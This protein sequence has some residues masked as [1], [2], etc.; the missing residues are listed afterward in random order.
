MAAGAGAL[1]DLRPR[2][3]SGH[4]WTLAGYFR[5]RFE[6]SRPP[7]SRPFELRV[8]DPRMGRLRLTGRLSGGGDSLV[9]VLHGIAGNCDSGYAVRAALAAE[10][11]GWS[12]LRLNMRGAD[13][14][15]EDLFHAGLT[16]DLHSV[17]ACAELAR[18][19]TLHVLGFSLG[20][21]VA[22]RA[23]TQPVDPRLR[24]VAAVCS[25]L[26][27]SACA[28][29]FDRPVSW[30]YRWRILAELSRRYEG[31]AAR[32]P[33]PV[34]PRRVHR[35]RTLREFD[36]LT[37]APRFGFA[38]AEDY[39]RRMSVGPVLARLGVPSLLVV[40]VSDP[41]VPLATLAPFVRAPPPALTIRY[42]DPGGHVGFPGGV[43]LGVEAPPGLESQAI[44]WL[45]GQRA[46]GAG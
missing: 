14:S 21:H 2:G 31:V 17:L 10:R 29:A 40:G 44:A 32:R 9:V 18:Y 7:S 46:S 34:E 19:R 45:G 8:L 6:R 1:A 16:D 30:A 11:A 22:L 26:D 20:G 39:Y 25:P 28:T 33:V 23:A 15:G 24:S 38:D 42:L 41:L 36:G 37:V 27:L 4:F 35:A 43:D 5:S 12:C 13:S 3:L